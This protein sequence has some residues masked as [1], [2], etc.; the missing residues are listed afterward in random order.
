MNAHPLAS[1]FSLTVQQDPDTGDLFVRLPPELLATMDW[2]EGDRLEYVVREGE[3]LELINHCKAERDR[4]V[5][6]EQPEQPDMPLF[7]VETVLSHRM[8]Y[9]VRARSAEHAMDIITMEEANE[10]DQN[11]L[12]EQIFSTRQVS[13]DE[14]LNSAELPTDP[15]AK[16]AYIHTVDYSQDAPPAGT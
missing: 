4:L 15:K 2:R 12:G 11:F 6:N 16:L 8:R 5:Q 14:F 9:A 1:S 7:I 3:C 13:I 10:F